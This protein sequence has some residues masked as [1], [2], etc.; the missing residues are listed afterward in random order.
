MK[1]C[2]G[3]DLGGTTVKIGMLS[4]DGTISD[5]WE[6]PSRKEEGG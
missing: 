4:E 3:V 2:V 5:K 1:K 6:I